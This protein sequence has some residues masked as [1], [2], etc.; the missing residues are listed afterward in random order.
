MTEELR[1]ELDTLLK[2]RKEDEE[3]IEELAFLV[4]K[5]EE[6]CEFEGLPVDMQGYKKVL[7]RLGYVV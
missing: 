6:G 1:K 3:K 5:Q 7:R 4:Y 2:K